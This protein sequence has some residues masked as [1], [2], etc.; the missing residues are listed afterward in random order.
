MSSIRIY[1]LLIFLASSTII[2]AQQ[3]LTLNEA[4]K[5]ALENNF[6]IQVSKNDAAIISNNNSAGAAGM[7]PVVTG[8][9]NQ[10]NQI[11]D[12]KQQ[13]LNGTENNRDGAKSNNL[14][15]NV[16]L[17]WTIF[18]GFKMFATRNKLNELQQIGQ[19]KMQANIEQIF[20]KV[21][22][23]YYDVAVAKQQLVLTDYTF[24]NS[25]KRLELAKEKYNVG[26]SPKS[27]LLK[28]QVDLNADKALLL[29][30][31]NT[32]QNAKTNLNQL[33]ARDLTTAF[34]IAPIDLISSTFNVDELLTKVNAKNT[35]LL[36]I[37]KTKQVNLLQL[38][39]IKAERMPTLQ[40]KSGYNI[41]RQE[42]EAGFLQS[43]QNNGFHYGVGLSINL[44]NGYNVNNRI[45]NAQLQLKSTELIYTDSLTKL[46]QQFQ[47]AYN[48][49]LLSTTLINLEK[50]NVKVAK[51]NYDIASE[52][53]KMGVITSI[54]LRDAQQNLLASELR[55]LTATYES[56]LNETELLRLSGELVKL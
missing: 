35:T 52:Q 1:L 24:K 14:N 23:A 30:Q 26:K 21:T 6:A 33:L 55:L 25:E 27:E 50:E 41:Q 36:M 42:S 10:D 44:F 49:Y 56:K 45:K 16:E 19:L 54:E 18:D 12:T 29:R 22:K 17:G 46:Q 15:A 9:I 43:S 5:I 31:Q 38:K 13:F 37:K 47:A 40:L 2:N 7:L 32:L 8:T 20:L 3:V 28:A 48:N 4:L 39:E 34:E 53:Y 11:I 51:E